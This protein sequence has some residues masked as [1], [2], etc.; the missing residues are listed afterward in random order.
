[1]TTEAAER[2]R[3]ARCEYVFGGTRNQ[4]GVTPD[5][6]IHVGGEWRGPEE[7]HFFA[8]ERSAGAAPL[9]VERLAQT[10]ADVGLD[11][12]IETGNEDARDG[13]R[14]MVFD[15]DRWAA[16]ILARLLDAAPTDGEDR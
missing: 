1:M 9:D 8:H 6:A 15:Y 16:A 3:D 10:A 4:C 12:W 13:F 7:Y 14:E 5:H 11:F 2:L